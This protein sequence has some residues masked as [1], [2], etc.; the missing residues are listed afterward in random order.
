LNQATIKH[1]HEVK[2]R[3]G[4]LYLK[5]PR[6]LMYS[7]I[8]ASLLF[9]FF[10]GK[11]LFDALSFPS[12]FYVLAHNFVQKTDERRKTAAQPPNWVQ[13]IPFPH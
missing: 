4:F 13:N 1:P 12:T 10:Q 11:T 2:R 9:D 7:Y 8:L 6:N 5:T 3:E